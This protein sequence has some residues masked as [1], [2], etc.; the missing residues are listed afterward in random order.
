MFK[1]VSYSTGL[2]TSVRSAD[3]DDSSYV[4]DRILAQPPGCQVQ[5]NDLLIG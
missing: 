2:V 1:I 5:C 4:G 3:F